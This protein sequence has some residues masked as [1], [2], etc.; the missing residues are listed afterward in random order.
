MYISFT[1]TAMSPWLFPFS[2]IAPCK[3]KRAICSSL[4]QVS[5]TRLASFSNVS[6]K[7]SLH[8]VAKVVVNADHYNDM[9]GLDTY[10]VSH[11]EL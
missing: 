6:L 5:C 7:C 2:S 11:P 3:L 4:Y 9:Y 10:K 8:G 1:V